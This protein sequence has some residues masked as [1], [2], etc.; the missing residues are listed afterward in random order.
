MNKLEQKK[1]SESLHKIAMMGHGIKDEMRD[2]GNIGRN[3]VYTAREAI[4]GICP[5]CKRPK[6]FKPKARLP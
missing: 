3:A 4:V 6:E 1:M 5:K 2:W